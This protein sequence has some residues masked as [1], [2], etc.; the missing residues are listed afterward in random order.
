MFSRIHHIVRKL[1]SK[2]WIIYRIVRDRSIFMQNFQNP[3]SA[4]CVVCVCFFQFCSAIR[5]KSSWW[6]FEFEKWPTGTGWN[7]IFI[8]DTTTTATETWCCAPSQGGKV[9]RKANDCNDALIIIWKHGHKHGRAQQQQ[10]M[11]VRFD[12]L[13]ASPGEELFELCLA[14]KNKVETNKKKKKK[15]NRYCLNVFSFF[16]WKQWQLRETWPG[17]GEEPL[18]ANKLY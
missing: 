17:A 14:R 18:F 13:L 11:A 2:V 16:R 4:D 9:R 7:W 1:P 8:K 12:S 5:N 6:T 3:S 10:K 15:P